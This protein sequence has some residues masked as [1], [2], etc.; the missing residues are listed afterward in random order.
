MRGDGRTDPLRSTGGNKLV[1][2]VAVPLLIAGL[3]GLS[4]FCFQFPCKC[5]CL[6]T[7]L[8][9]LGT[10]ASAQANK[11]FPYLDNCYRNSSQSAFDLQLTR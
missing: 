4:C 6:H 5:L 11:G 7:C 1:S 8:S 3:Q 2:F 10:G 9:Y